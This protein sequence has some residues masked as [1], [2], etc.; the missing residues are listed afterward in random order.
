MISYTPGPRRGPST[1][2]GPSG[3]T[4][5]FS[6]FNIFTTAFHWGRLSFTSWRWFYFFPLFPCQL[7][8]VCSSPS[9][10]A[11]PM[12]EDVHDCVSLLFPFWDRDLTQCFLC[13]PLMPLKT[14]SNILRCQ[15]APVRKVTEACPDI[16]AMFLARSP[17]LLLP[18]VC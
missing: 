10:R 2:R 14:N 12:R 3:S 11:L 9:A 13:L 17:H 6:A 1:H 4:M 16:C 15:T 5:R 18:Y 8:S 7:I